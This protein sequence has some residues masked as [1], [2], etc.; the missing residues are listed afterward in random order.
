MGG[1]GAVLGQPSHHPTHTTI[2]PSAFPSRISALPSESSCWISAPLESSLSPSWHWPGNELLVLPWVAAKGRGQ[3]GQGRRGCRVSPVDAEGTEA[4]HRD[5]HGG[6][7][8][9][10]HQLADLHS[11]GPVLGQ[12]LGR[13][14]R[15]PGCFGNV[16]PAPCG[17]TGSPT[18]CG[19][20]SESRGSS[21]RFPPLGMFRGHSPM[22]CRHWETLVS[23][24]GH[25][26][27]GW[28]RHQLLTPDPGGLER[29]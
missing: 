26:D 24:S 1:M 29:I 3:A 2:F 13:S 17:S 12:E 10:G 15:L 21:L 7:L 5:A 23:L 25:R 28:S 19:E 20:P 14:H 27:E 4:E 11:E 16:L 22:V 18:G 9:E 6:L 8:D